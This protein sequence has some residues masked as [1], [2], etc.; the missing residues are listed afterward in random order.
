M[1]HSVL[2]LRNITANKRDES[3]VL[4]KLYSNQKQGGEVGGDRH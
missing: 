2:A 1:L 3:P 4:L